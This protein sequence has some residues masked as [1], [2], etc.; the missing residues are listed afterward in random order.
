[1]DSSRFEEGAREC[2]LV[3]RH[4]TANLHL[5]HERKERTSHRRPVTEDVTQTNPTGQSSTC[6]LERK[7]C[8][9]PKE[10]TTQGCLISNAWNAS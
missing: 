6:T 3:C 5:D 7:E 2:L 8:P 1:M 9:K 10:A 4:H